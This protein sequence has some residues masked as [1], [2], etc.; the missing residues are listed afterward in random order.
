[1][2]KVKLSVVLTQEQVDFL[3]A[4]ATEMTSTR[5]YLIRKIIQDHI[6][7]KKAKETE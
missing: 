2:A 6:N 1:M 4:E 7:D 3:E 5:T